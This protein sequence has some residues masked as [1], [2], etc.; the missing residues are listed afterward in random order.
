LLANLMTKGVSKSLT[1]SALAASSAA[2]TTVD[3]GCEV[4]VSLGPVVD[5][6]RSG[7]KGGTA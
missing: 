2:W 1:R 6:S 5:V 7:Q 3:I 4:E